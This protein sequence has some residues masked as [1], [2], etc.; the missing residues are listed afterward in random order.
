M[1]PRIAPA[2][3]LKMPGW[4]E[5][6]DEET[7]R[8][9]LTRL[10]AR[11]FE[12]GFRQKPQADSDLIFPHFQ[13]GVIFEYNVNWKKISD[14]DAKEYYDKSNPYYVDP[15]WPRYTGCDLSTRKRRGTVIFTLAIA[16]DGTRH[17]LDI[18]LGKWGAGREF[19]N[20]L[21]A[22]DDNLLLRPRVIFVENNALQSE[23]IHWIRDIEA[24]C[25]TKVEGFHTG[26]NK[27][28]AEIGL[29]GI[30]IQ[31]SERR[32]KV[33]VPHPQNRP[34]EPDPKDPTLCMC[35]LCTLIDSTLVFTRD[36]VGET[37]DVIMA[38][39]IAKEASRQGERYTTTSASVIRISR[40]DISQNISKIAAKHRGQDY[41]IPVSYNNRAY[42]SA[43]RPRP[44]LDEFGRR[45][46]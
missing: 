5:K 31:Y 19:V 40:D 20:Q 17:V 4:P 10:R 30:D 2:T 9:I 29:P 43:R 46:R 37:P 45:L 21:Q 28:D 35:G 27:L 42:P 14:P 13:Q 15:N 39:F 12:R 18:R 8:D 38:Q 41:H 24:P 36:D 3:K 22:V 33:G 7:L 11:A 16:P 25:W 32:W 34:S 26:S 6:F 44:G 23:L 1:A